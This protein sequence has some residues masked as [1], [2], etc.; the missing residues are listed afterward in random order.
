MT[1]VAQYSGAQVELLLGANILEAVVQREA[2][3]GGPGQPVSVRTD[4]SW[5]LTGSI[6]TLVPSTTRKV[7]FVRRPPSED[8]R[9][10]ERVQEWRKAEDTATNTEKQMAPNTTAERTAADATERT[11]EAGAS[12]DGAHTIIVKLKLLNDKQ[13]LVEGRRAEPMAEFKGRH[14]KRTAAAT[15]T[16]ANPIIRI[17]VLL[18]PVLIAV[19]MLVWDQ[20]LRYPDLF[21]GAA[22][23]LLAK[24]TLLF[25]CFASATFLPLELLPARRRTDQ[26]QQRQGFRGGVTATRPTSGILITFPNLSWRSE[27][28]SRGVSPSGHRGLS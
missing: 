24:M 6:S 14:R 16:A 21:S 2:R 15:E 8:E 7:M 3:V 18:Y 13:R 23:L 17:G 27:G 12:S 5:T 4:F 22:V 20:R 1:I 10:S 25:A 9:L 28:G 26:F 11:P 19:G